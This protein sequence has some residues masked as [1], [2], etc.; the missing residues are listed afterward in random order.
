[1]SKISESQIVASGELEISVVMYED[2]C[3]WIAQ[4]I[5]YDITAR[6]ASPAEAARRFDRKVG[7]ELVMSFE[8]GDQVPLAGVG[9]APQKFWRMFTDSHETLSHE[10][11]PMRVDRDGG[12]VV[13]R[14]SPRIKIAQLAA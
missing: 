1:M 5:E 4:G 2:N 6:G 7:A 8:L 9:P 10:R 12:V 3:V 14:V 13:P 11:S